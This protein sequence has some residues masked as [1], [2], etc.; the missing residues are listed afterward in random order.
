M[1]LQRTPV[2]LMLAALLLGAIVYIRESDNSA[3]QK[4]AQTLAQQKL[5]PFKEDEI[6]SL[7]IQTQ[8]QTLAFA[9]T[10][11][12]QPP[13]SPTPTASVRSSPTRWTMTA[14]K[15][16][17]ANDASIAYLLNL[18][19]IGNREQPI[20]VS[21]S[22]QAEFGFDK[23]LATVEVKRLNQ[24]THRLILGKPNFN[25]SRLY[26]QIDPPA[27]TDLTVQLVSIDFESAVTR[28]PS[29]WLK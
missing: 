4:S 18:M 21:S 29:E 2:A 7:T 10:P 24:Q 5:F 11:A 22:K 25:R 14:P 19:A 27:G 26:A 16:T 1:K 9:K 12:P 23:P 28:A 13:N 17:A 8:S 20:V 15:Q 3:Q 6:Q